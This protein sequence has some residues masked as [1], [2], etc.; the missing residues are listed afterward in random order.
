MILFATGIKV[1][2]PK[3]KKLWAFCPNLSLS[4]VGPC[5]TA[6]TSWLPLVALAEMGDLCGMISWLWEVVGC[7]MGWRRIKAN[8]NVGSTMLITIAGVKRSYFFDL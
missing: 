4:L 5:Q 3:L 7:G 6:P 1:V 8:K 2:T